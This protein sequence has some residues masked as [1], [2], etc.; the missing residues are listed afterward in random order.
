M[1]FRVAQVSDTHLSRDKPFF[2]AN[3]AAAAAGVAASRPDLVVNTGDLSLDGAGT[4]SDLEEARRLHDALRLPTRFIPGN[5]DVG[6]SSF[7]C[8]IVS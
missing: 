4:E 6:E 5:H 3:F 7:P 2:A 1:T 8:C